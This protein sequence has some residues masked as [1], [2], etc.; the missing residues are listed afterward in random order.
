[1]EN[2]DKRPWGYYEIISDESDHK[3]KRICVEPKNRLSYQYHKKRQ[4]HWFIVSGEALVT[5]DGKQIKLK[6][7][8]SI[9]ISKKALHRIQNPSD[10]RM[11]IFIEIQTGEY[12]EEDDIVR[13]EDDYNRADQE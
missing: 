6:P 13:V 4:E 3:V 1:M 12:F 9:N 8:D 11:L 10:K 5:L 2:K 7:G